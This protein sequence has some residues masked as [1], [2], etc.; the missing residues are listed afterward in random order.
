MMTLESQHGF[1]A[2]IGIA[3]MVAVRQPR[4]D[5]SQVARPDWPAAQH[6]QGLCAGRPP[7]HQYESHVAPPS[8]KQNTVSDGWKVL[9]GG[10]QR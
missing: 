3:I 5:L 8:A 7:V 1:L 4:L 6:T 2:V 9:G 10:A